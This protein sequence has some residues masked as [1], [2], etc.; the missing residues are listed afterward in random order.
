MDI[1]EVTMEEEET[2]VPNKEEQQSIQI[3]D[4]YKN[5]GAVAQWEQ[6]LKSAHYSSTLPAG[7]LEVDKLQDDP[8]FCIQTFLPP[9]EMEARCA[10]LIAQFHS[11]KGIPQQSRLRVSDLAYYNLAHDTAETEVWRGI[12]NF[13]QP[14]ATCIK[15]VPQSQQSGD[16]SI[17]EDR[18]RASWHPVFGHLVR[19]APREPS[20]RSWG[21]EGDLAAFRCEG[22]SARLTRAPTFGSST[23]S[24]REW[25]SNV[26]NGYLNVSDEW[27]V[28]D[29]ADASSLG[30]PES[31]ISNCSALINHDHECTAPSNLFPASPVISLGPAPAA[32]GIEYTGPNPSATLDQRLDDHADA[33]IASDDGDLESASLR[34]AER[35]Y[36]V[37]FVIVIICFV[38]G[39]IAAIVGAFVFAARRGIL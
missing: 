28:Y 2:I 35:P 13:R 38:A 23:A 12:L 27:I 22:T 16:S 5:S 24:D 15:A 26:L 8:T 29:E 31:V 21:S 32:T 3:H 30:L 34:R 20:L 7:Y 39:S 36:L 19:P 17:E 4:D 33:S 14:D 25:V 18:A 6:F 10:T 1:V 11:F 9:L 37:I